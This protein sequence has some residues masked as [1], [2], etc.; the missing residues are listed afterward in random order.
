MTSAADYLDFAYRTALAAGAVTLPHFRVPI[1]V[2][3]KGVSGYDPV[4]AADRDAEAVLRAEIAKAYPDHGI[5]GEEHGFERGRSPYTWVVDPIDGTRSFITGLLHWGMLVALHDGRR[6]VCGLAHQPYV[7]ETFL[8]VAGE[9]SRWRRGAD[10]RVLA[11][12]RCPDVESAIVV[13]T[14]PDM[15]VTPRTQEGFARVRA[16]AKLT[17]FGGDCYAYCLLAMGLIDIVI[18][19]GLEAWDVQALIPIVEGAG[20]TVTSW[21]GGNCEEGGDVLA[22]GDPSL[23][24]AVRA[25]LAGKRAPASGRGA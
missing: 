2:I 17:R 25:L 7:G 1:P 16:R 6:V 19:S 11:T 15:F 20:G 10:E 9:R 22:C 3:D 12:R 21:D 5:R 23:A 14:T 24:P 13:C 8:A 18:E 4:T